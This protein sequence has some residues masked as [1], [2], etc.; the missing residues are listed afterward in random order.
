MEMLTGWPSWGPASGNVFVLGAGGA[1]PLIPA[2]SPGV[3]P[4]KSSLWEVLSEVTPKQAS[5]SL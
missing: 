5:A 3:S 4:Q 2:H 1:V